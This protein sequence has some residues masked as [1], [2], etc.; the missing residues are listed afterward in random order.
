[1]RDRWL[2]AGVGFAL[3]LVSAGCKEPLDAKET[4]L[5]R[6]KTLPALA[7]QPDRLETWQRAAE[8]T[9]QGIKALKAERWADARQLLAEAVQVSP[10]YP[11]A[12]LQLALLYERAGLGSVA[13]ALLQPCKEAKEPSG[14]CRYLLQQY[15][16][17]GDFARL[18]KTEAGA[19][20]LSGLPASPNLVD[21]ADRLAAALQKADPVAATAFASTGM[22]FDLIRSCPSCPTEAQQR[23]E[24]RPLIGAA[25]MARLALR[26]ASSDP[27]ARGTPLLVGSPKSCDGLCCSWPVP[28]PVPDNQAA[29]DHVCLL[30]DGATEAVATEVEVV[31]GNVARVNRFQQL[32]GVP[33]LPAPATPTDK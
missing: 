32:P 19:A 7:E 20:A 31:Y 16:T 14:S 26:F 9:A 5:E 13:L 24:H 18:R 21:A 15:A 28:K 33:T 1:M 3:V 27:A 22:G 6:P 29:L 12:R 2:R 8:L 30:P 25:M 11:E 17:S 23:R 4:K 10:A